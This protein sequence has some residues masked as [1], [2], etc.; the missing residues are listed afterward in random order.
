MSTARQSGNPRGRPRSVRA[1]QAILEATRDLLTESGYERLS[2][3]AIAGRAGVG[4]QTLYRWWPSKAAVV[5]EAVLG[6]Y[7]PTS[8][9][10]PPDTGDIGADLRA[11]G[12]GQIAWLTDPTSAA[13]VRGLAAAAADSDT[14]SARLY[15]ELATP[16][17]QDLLRRL[18][19]GVREGTLR[20]DADL[21]AAAD[22]I[23][24]SM[25]YR[26]MAGG[27][28]HLRDDLDGLVDLLIT[29]MRADQPPRPSG[30]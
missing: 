26:V 3:E 11:W 24:G 5:A 21:D 25:L 4:K 12:R 2:M 28:V 20:P 30:V 17:R 29:G 7:L 6:G 15:A 19:A 18:E 22:A 14:D 27:H 9:T 8:T 16:V 10:A 13:L 1:H 23:I